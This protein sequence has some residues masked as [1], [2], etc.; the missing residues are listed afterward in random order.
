M[1]ASQATVTGKV[2]PGST[3]TSQVFSNLTEFSLLTWPKN[4]M[5][6]TSNNKRQ[7]F[8]INATT[9]VTVTIASGVA[10]IVVSQ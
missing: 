9:T 4:V 5:F 6:I 3:I 2:G 10:T 8:D 7:D 1:P